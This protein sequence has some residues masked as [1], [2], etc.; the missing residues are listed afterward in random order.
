MWIL[1]GNGREMVNSDCIKRIFINVQPDVTLVGAEVGTA[2]P[3]CLG[4]YDQ[5]QTAE[6]ELANILQAIMDDRNYIMSGDRSDTHGP[7]KIM[8]SRVKRRGGS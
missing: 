8:D 6:G 1:S 3:A 2:K 5:V 4:K 7:R